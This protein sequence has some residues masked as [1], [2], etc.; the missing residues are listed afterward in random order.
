MRRAARCDGSRAARVETRFVSGPSVV[1]VIQARMGSTRLPGKVL[2][3][4]G[5]STVLEQMLARLAHAQCAGTLLVAT[6]TDPEDDDIELV[7]RRAGVRHYRG[8]PLDLLDRHYRVARALQAGVVVKIPSDCPL[9]DPEVVDRVIRAFL[10]HDGACDY[11]SNLHPPTYPDGNDVEVMSVAALE[12]AWERATR[13][14]ERE[15]TTPFLWD[16]PELFRLRNVTHETG[17]DLSWTHRV[18]LDYVE[19]YEVIRTL[20]DA[21]HPSDPLFRVA[22]VV[23]YLDTHPAVAALNAS[24]RGV[25]WYR[26]HLAELRTI[27][28]ADTRVA[29]EEIRS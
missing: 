4:L 2:L 8:S 6:T 13:D 26:H 7:C 15:H 16:H 27:T 28:A 22:D 21:L 19:D 10:N 11:A 25:N 14:F 17:A 29:H 3:P 9:I 20:F 5:S 1:T 23:Q 12:A 18:V 24:R